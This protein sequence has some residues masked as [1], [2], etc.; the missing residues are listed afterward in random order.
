MERIEI[1]GEKLERIMRSMDEEGRKIFEKLLLIAASKSPLK[2]IN[3]WLERFEDDCPVDNL[4]ARLVVQVIHNVG[5]KIWESM[6]ESKK[7]GDTHFTGHEAAMI[8]VGEVRKIADDFD[9]VT[10]EQCKHCEIKETTH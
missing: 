9:K 5:G 4:I 6:D 2:S 3:D 1:D 7:N 10:K 8:A